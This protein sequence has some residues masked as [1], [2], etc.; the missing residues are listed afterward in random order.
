MVYAVTDGCSPLSGAP[1]GEVW[2]TTQ[3]KRDTDG[4]R[5]CPDKAFLTVASPTL[6][7]TSQVTVTAIAASGRVPRSDRDSDRAIR[8]LYI[9]E[10]READ[11]PPAAFDPGVCHCSSRTRLDLTSNVSLVHYH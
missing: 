5:R 11:A 2:V 1:G 4:E 10:Q 6:V 8:I 3:R 9:C 7:G